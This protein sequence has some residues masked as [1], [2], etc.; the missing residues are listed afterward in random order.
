MQ[1]RTSLR[2][3]RQLN[4]ATSLKRSR[5]PV[6]YS[7]KHSDGFADGRDGGSS[8]AIESFQMSAR[9]ILWSLPLVLGTAWSALGQQ[10]G[11]PAV[12]QRLAETSCIECHALTNVPKRAPAFSSIASMPST[13]ALSLRV[14]L[15]TSHPTMPNIMLSPSERN[16]VIAYILSLRR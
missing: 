1:R 5:W 9:S 3:L 12:G 13:T 15:Q 4:N 7:L 11:D 16:D 8:K 10:L 14:F 6:A 2:I